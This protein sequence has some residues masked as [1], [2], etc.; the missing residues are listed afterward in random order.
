M[1]AL[2]F[3]LPSIAAYFLLFTTGTQFSACTKTN[4]VHDT[5]I[6]KDTVIRK[7]T[8]YDLTEGLVAYYNF[9]N[10][11]LKDSSSF[12]NDIFFSNATKTAD[13]FGNANNAYLFDG[14]T[15]YMQV[16][17]STSLNPSA[18]TMMA[19]IKLNGFYR[20][21]SY[22]NQIF[23]KG[24]SDNAQGI[25]GLRIQP[26]VFNS[27]DTAKDFPSGYFG[28]GGSFA[29]VTDTTYFFRTGKWVKLVTTYDGVQSKIYIDGQL[30]NAFAGG[31]AFTQTA[32]DLF[33]G[34]HENPSFPF[35]FN[36]I[37]DEVRIYNRA[38]G[39]GAITQWGNLTN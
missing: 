37:I 17:N 38:L 30:K 28:D 34:R 12:K 32:N 11:T 2:K 25:Y 10:G 35:W 33:I 1:K 8:I 5:L 39:Q 31:G 7:D 18:I 24:Y 36:G 26:L 16:K 29:N 22:G 14:T 3:I 4:T 19:I 27:P 23:M 9:N 15:S 20:G 13:R 21:P 6:K